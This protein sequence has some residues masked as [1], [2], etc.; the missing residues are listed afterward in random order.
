MFEY[1][2]SGTCSTKIVFSI[3]DGLLRNV[4]FHRGC[5]GNLKAISSLVEGSPVEE[6]VRKLAGIRCGARATSCAD[7]LCRA[8]SE[9][10]QLEA[11]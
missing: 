3:E 9:A 4:R 10:L 11:C 6:V 7:Q 1:S 5:D 8:I 2:T